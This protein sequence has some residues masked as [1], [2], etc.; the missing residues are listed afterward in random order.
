M[1]TSLRLTGWWRLWILFAAI[2]MVAVGAVTYSAWPS[3]DQAAHH[4]AFIYQL[5]VQQREL[6]AREGATSIGVA[7][8]MPNGYRLQFRPGVEESA[9][10]PV[11]RAYQHVTVRAQTEARRDSL[12]QFCLVALL[13]PIVLALLG[14][15][16]AWVRQ[17]FKAGGE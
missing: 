1:A 5:D 9:Y 10:A 16:V 8:D 15:G 2:W 12:K 14:M 17:G 11:A 7:V 13:P 3:E 6:L 4:P